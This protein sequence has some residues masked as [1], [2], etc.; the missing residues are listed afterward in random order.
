[1]AFN[2]MAFIVFFIAV[3]ALYYIVPRKYRWMFLLASSYFFYLYASAKFVIFIILTTITSYCAARYIDR[4]HKD[5]KKVNDNKDVDIK[6]RKAEKSK[7]KKKRKQALVMLLVLNFG[8]LVFLKYFNFFAANLNVVLESISFVG[9]IPKFNLILPLGI[10]FYTFQ[11]MSYVIDVYWGKIEAEKNFGK[12][13]LFVSFFPQIIEGPI[14]RFKDLAPTLF[15]QE[16][17]NMQNVVYG[18]QLMMWGF[19]KKMVIADRVAIIADYV[20]GH[21]MDISGMGVTFGVIMYA[22]QDYTDFSGCI[23]IARGCAK[24]MGIEMA[25]NFKRP[26]FSRSIPE[27]WRRWHMSL[28]AWMKDYVFYPFSLTKGVRNLGKSTK[29][30]FGKFIGLTLPVALGNILVFFLVG[31]WH[32]ASWNYIV[33]GLFYGILIAS[34]AFLK[35]AFTWMVDKLHINVEAKWFMVFQIARTFWITCV[36]CIIFRAD[37]LGNAWDVL[38]KSFQVFQIPPH[39]VKE[40]LSFGLDAQNY[41]ALFVCLVILFVVDVMQE[42][43][44]VRD[45]F[46][47]RPMI[48]RILIY[49][50]GFIIIFT[51]GVYGPGV[52]ANQFVYMQF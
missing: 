33:W 16:K 38:M 42:K 40:M 50:I 44:V 13:A 17:G 36:G 29:K 15:S 34:A 7:I 9:K 22:I 4:T 49:M 47:Q 31:V 3:L 35:P 26:Y 12:V 51:L 10:S 52:S 21:Y 39:F 46:A 28:G 2:T 45:W 19:F 48:V 1:M 32:G 23:D 8:I 5:E 14:G 37:G 25:E 41:I 11:T 20:F 18:V 24:A 30:R 27:F 43:M 6:I